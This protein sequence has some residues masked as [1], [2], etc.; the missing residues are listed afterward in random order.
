VKTPSRSTN[1]SPLLVGLAIAGLIGLVFALFLLPSFLSIP[2]DDKD[3][4]RGA[5]SH[6]QA[7]NM[8]QQAYYLE[9]DTFT[10]SYSHLEIFHKYKRD[11]DSS[12]GYHVKI[13]YA[14]TKLAIVKA[15]PKRDN[16]KP[17]TGAAFAQADGITRVIV[18]EPK[19]ITQTL[20]DPIIIRNNLEC[21]ANSTQFSGYYPVMMTSSNKSPLLD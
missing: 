11:A 2:E 18:C 1:F 9:H 8:G 16:L 3:R 5:V 17:Y 19:E 4:Q 21:G 12:E 6:L 15:I 13:T 20:Y 14:G 7:V 10:S